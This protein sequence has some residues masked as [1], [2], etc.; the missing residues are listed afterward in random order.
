MIPT[1]LQDAI[2]ERLNVLFDGDSFKK[3]LP[4]GT[5]SPA[6]LSV[7]AQGLP[8]KQ[9]EHDIQFPFVIVKLMQARQE[10]PDLAP[11]VRIGFIVGLYD[12]APDNQGYRDLVRV[13]NRIVEDFKERPLTARYFELTYPIE[14]APYEE[15]TAPQ[16]LGSI[17]TYWEAP[18]LIRRD[19]EGLI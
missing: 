11:R 17:D 16:W 6:P 8:A 1:I 13:L 4:D 10:K 7:F 14:V 19:V 15:E 9:S 18:I 2:I 3:P 12:D 5:V